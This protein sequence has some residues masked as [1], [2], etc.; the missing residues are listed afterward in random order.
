LIIIS[1]C[2]EEKVAPDLNNVK[3]AFIADVH[4][5]DIYGS[6]Q[7]SDFGIINPENRKKAIIRTMEAQIHSTRIFNENYF[8]FIATL[9]D[10][11]KRS[12]DYVIFPGDFSDDGQA[13]HLKGLQNI[14][15]KYT[16]DHGIK[17]FIIIGN[18]DPYKPFTFNS[19]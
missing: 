11:V 12:I 9:D 10:A 16:K 17:F 15:D 3:I 4:F 13:I 18:H 7:D 6:F 8:A 19:W 2:K 1:S 14:L 5:N